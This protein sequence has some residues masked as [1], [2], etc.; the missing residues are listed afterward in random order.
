[1][2]IRA[3]V[4]DA[5]TLFAAGRHEGA[6]L[7]VLI[8]IAATSRRRKPDGTGSQKHAGKLMGDGEA[9]EAFLAD[10]MVNICRVQNFNV[11]FRGKLHRLE[12]ILYK[13]LRCELAHKA[14]LPSDVVFD[15]PTVPGQM[16]IAVDP[17]TGIRLS[18]GWLD[19]LV[20]SVVNASENRDQFGD[21]PQPPFPLYL[22]GFDLTLSNVPILPNGVVQP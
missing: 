16:S 6:L 7:S 22:P 10:E 15:S 1:M 12:H 17:N 9:F 3:R 21:P 5:I 11:M 18:H 4:E 19:G 8:A 14:G 2:S 13:W 20:N